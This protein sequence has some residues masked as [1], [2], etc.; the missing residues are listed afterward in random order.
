MGM[1]KKR[2]LMWRGM[3]EMRMLMMMIRMMYSVVGG[4]LEC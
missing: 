2:M 4:G 1:R 3:C